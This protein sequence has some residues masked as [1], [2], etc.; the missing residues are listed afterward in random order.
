[1]IDRRDWMARLAAA[2]AAGPL[3]SGK[4]IGIVPFV[5]EGTAPMDVVVDRELDGRLY[6]DLSKLRYGQSVTPTEIFYIRTR[7]S[8][9]LPLPAQWRLRLDDGDSILENSTGRLIARSMPMGVHVMECSGNS[10]GA[11]FGMLSAAHWEGTL[12]QELL[13]YGLWKTRSELILVSGFDSYKGLS[14]SS[15]PGASWIFSARD[16]LSSGAFLAT[17]M[18]GESLSK[19]HGAPLRLVVPGWYGCYC[20][21]W[22]NKISFV[23]PSARATA[24][25]V[26]YASRTHQA[27]VPA[28]AIDFAPAKVDSAAIPIRVER[29]LV[30]GGV[31]HRV[32][33]LAWG[34][35]APVRTLVIRFEPENQTY[36]IKNLQSPV[37][38]AW[39]FWTFEWKPKYHTRYD[40]FL[41][42]KEPQCRTRRLDLKYYRRSVIIE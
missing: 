35:D 15:I 28:K 11:R 20:I 27:G 6:T 13:E 19:D 1:M 14:T 2:I 29:W 4:F 8:L 22:V 26:E 10:R 5:G 12:I 33:G 17:R 9:L 36:T 32:F 38:G 34:G 41:T 40:I 18:N 24:Q 37:Q 3:P 39:Q 42:V 7:A 31:V 16:L 21:K 30:R 23:P 25:M